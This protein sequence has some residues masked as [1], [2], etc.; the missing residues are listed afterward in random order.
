MFNF[1]V[2]SMLATHARAAAL[3]ERLAEVDRAL[4]GLGGKSYLSGHTGYGP[5]AWREHYGAA[6]AEGLAAK[7]AFDP[8]G[9]FGAPGAPFAGAI[10]R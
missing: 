4:V 6:L 9:V 2:L 5:D 7:R 3:S 10:T 1:A 8:Q